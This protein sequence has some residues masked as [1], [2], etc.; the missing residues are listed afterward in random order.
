MDDGAPGNHLRVPLPAVQYHRADGLMFLPSLHGWLY[1][2]LLPACKVSERAI[3]DED[4]VVFVWCGADGLLL[5]LSGGVCEFADAG[6]RRASDVRDG[7]EEWLAR[8]MEVRAW[9]Y[10]VQLGICVLWAPFA[11]YGFEYRAGQL[12]GLCLYFGGFFGFGGVA[13]VIFHHF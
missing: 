1:L 11:L 9:F 8:A 7:V 6:V 4:G 10:I 12:E 3:F 13:S 5:E 2:E